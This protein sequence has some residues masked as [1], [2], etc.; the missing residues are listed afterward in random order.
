VAR[1]R[2]NAPQHTI[3]DAFASITREI[4]FPT[5]LEHTHVLPSPSL[6]SSRQWVNIMFITN[7]VCTLVKVVVTDPIE[8]HLVLQTMIF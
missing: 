8:T 6:L 5:S 7:R 3:Q 4:K 2:I 1:E